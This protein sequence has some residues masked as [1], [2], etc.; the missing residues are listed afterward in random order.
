MENGY[1]IEFFE[2]HIIG[3]TFDFGLQEVAPNMVGFK[4]DNQFRKAQV[5]F[6]KDKITFN[7]RG[8]FTGSNKGIRTLS[9]KQITSADADT[10]FLSNHATLH[11]H[12]EE[13]ILDNPNKGTI[14]GIVAYINYMI[15]IDVSN[16]NEPVFSP[17]D[18][19]RKFKGLFDD[20]II[21]ETEWLAKKD[22]L[23][24]L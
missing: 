11:L 10:G 20:G 14:N 7:K 16:V 1:T 12:N 19:I 13:I 9:Y 17:A 6:G 15:D 18:E 5:T 3:K 23:L 24:N 21:T 8:F 4:K 22:E 2:E